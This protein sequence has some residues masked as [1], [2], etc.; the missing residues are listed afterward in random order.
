V[1]ATYREAETLVSEASS[2][3]YQRERSVDGMR[4]VVDM[5]T[6]ARTMIGEV[7]PLRHHDSLLRLLEKDLGT[8]YMLLAEMTWDVGAARQA[9]LTLEH[10]YLTPQDTVAAHAQDRQVEY[11]G[12]L[13]VPP[14]DLLGLM[15]GARLAAHRLWGEPDNLNAAMDLARRALAENTRAAS[16]TRSPRQ[17][18]DARAQHIGYD[19]NALATIGTEIALFRASPEAARA[20]TTSSDSAW[21][22]R[23][24]FRHEW[25]AYGSLLFERGRA[26]LALGEISGQ[27]AALDTAEVYLRACIDYRGPERPRTHAETRETL[28]R[29]E[30]VRARL[31]PPEERPALLRACLADLAAA[32]A[33]LARTPSAPAQL[34]WLRAE[35]SEPFVE[36]ALATRDAAALDSAQARLD[37]AAQAFPPTSLP[38]HAS[39]EWVRSGRL[40]LARYALGGGAADLEAARA[41]LSH[42]RSLAQSRHD[43]LVL[44]LVESIERGLPPL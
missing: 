26:F 9:V 44:G 1:L 29:L 5:L 8:A 32:R 11:L 28:A 15:A 43:T 39:L 25:P 37:E 17:A 21:E 24:D 13:Q 2:I 41:D 35:Q 19:H 16:D 27:R 6:R 7:P 18:R 23:D 4:Q 22:R 20:A 10:A 36:L 38:R 14:A 40:K 3:L 31:S 34:A 33:A 42:A 12:D 30:L